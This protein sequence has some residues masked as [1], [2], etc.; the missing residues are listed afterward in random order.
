MIMIVH[1][2]LMNLK[3]NVLSSAVVNATL[4]EGR[5]CWKWGYCMHYKIFSAHT[6]AGYP[7]CS[8]STR[9]WW[10]TWTSWSPRFD[11]IAGPERREGS[12]CECSVWVGGGLVEMWIV[13]HGVMQ[14]FLC[15]EICRVILEML[16]RMV[17][18]AN[19]AKEDHGETQDQQV[20]LVTQ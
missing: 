6:H 15:L 12:S 13:M 9:D 11:R 20:P 5:F 1:W 19:Q 7:R 2:L 16:E 4:V 17:Y 10:K 14:I 8:W 18:M 3:W